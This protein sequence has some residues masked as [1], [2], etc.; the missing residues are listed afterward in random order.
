M[1]QSMPY[2]G[3]KWLTSKQIKR[4]I[5]RDYSE[6]CSNNLPKGYI[7]EVDLDYPEEL[8][9]L[10]NEYPYCPEH[11]PITEDMLSEYSKHIAEE[12]N[13]EQSDCSK[14][15]QTLGDKKKYVIHERNLRQA[16]DAGLVLRKIHRILEFD[17]KPWM[18]DYIDFNTNKRKEA[19][20]DF[21]KDFFKLMNNSVFGKT[22]ENV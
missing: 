11:I 4:F 13:I 12:N 19:K 3:F 20:N 1:S 16:I 21:E 14:L 6:L 10:H 22:M 5:L 18:K 9:D 17:Q 2:G 8:H 7:L 15:L